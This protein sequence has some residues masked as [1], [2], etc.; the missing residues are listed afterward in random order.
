MQR[1]DSTAPAAPVALSPQTADDYSLAYERSGPL[2]FRFTLYA[3]FEKNRIDVLPFNFRA[4]AQ[5]PNAVGVPTNAGLLQSRGI[6]FFLRRGGLQFVANYART[7]TSSVDQFAYN[8]LN[9]AA[10]LAGHLYPAGY[11]PDFTATLSY[12]FGLAHRRVRVTPLISFESG[13]PYG[14]GTMV[15]IVNPKTGA[16]ELVRNDNYV[17]PG[18][19]YYFLKNPALPYDAAG[20]PLHR[21]ARH[22]RGRRSEHAAHAGADAGL[23]ARGGRRLVPSH[24]DAGRHQPLRDGGA[25]AAAG[26]SVPHRSAG[27]HRRQSAC[28]SAPTARSTAKAVSTRWATACRRTTAARRSCRGPTGRRDTCRSRIRWGAPRSYAFAIACSSF[29]IRT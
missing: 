9:P 27:L 19:S 7:Y 21:I 5:N 13:Y 15:W 2:T 29:S 12:E 1:T 18:Y 22:E 17:N 8:D 16:A 10:I 11:V 6:E 14:N 24:G 26:Q 3:N 23:G 28:T 25:D 20:N 4:T